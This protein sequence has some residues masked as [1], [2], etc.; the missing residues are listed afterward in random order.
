MN[1]ALAKIAEMWTA[2]AVVMMPETV[3]IRV[4]GKDNI[5][6]FKDITIDDIV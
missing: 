4:M 6:I 5:P 3:S 1:Q 2:T